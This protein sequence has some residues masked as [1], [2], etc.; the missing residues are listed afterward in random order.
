[1]GVKNFC[2]RI[3]DVRSS[4]S[5]PCQFGVRQQRHWSHSCR[6]FDISHK[7]WMSGQYMQKLLPLKTL[8]PTKFQKMFWMFVLVF[9]PRFYSEESHVE[10]SRTV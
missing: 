2:F 6:I 10:E 5:D 9:V 7:L 3:K 4:K 8:S 1:M